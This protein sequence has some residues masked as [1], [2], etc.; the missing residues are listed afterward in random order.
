[1]VVD[2]SPRPRP[3][4][5]EDRLRFVEVEHGANRPPV[6]RLRRWDG[7]RMVARLAAR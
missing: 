5:D 1:V 7:D 4:P 3:R 2:G 6:G